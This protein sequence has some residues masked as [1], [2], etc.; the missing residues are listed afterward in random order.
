VSRTVT[1]Y[2]SKIVMDSFRLS[3]A[4]MTLSQTV[5]QHSVC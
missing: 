1:D 3:H 4:I 2:L 5:T